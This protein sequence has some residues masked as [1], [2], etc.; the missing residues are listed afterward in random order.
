[1]ATKR[2]DS[3]GLPAAL[4]F[5]RVPVNRHFGFSLLSV[6]RGAAEV[7]MPLK[8]PFLQEEGVVHGGVLTTLAD[9]AAV[10]TL[11]PFLEDG[12]TMSS[13]ELKLNFLR[14]VFIDD[15]SVTAKAKLVR[16]GKRVALVQVNVNQAR[17][18]VATGMFTYLLYK[19]NDTNG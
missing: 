3:R 12:Q 15:G 6:R 14:P 17:R 18:L 2:D 16:Q 11:Y 7:A 4:D 9:S 10:Y 8:R 13:I 5:G 1:V 19:R